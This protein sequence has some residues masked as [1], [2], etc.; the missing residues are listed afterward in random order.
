NKRLLCHRN[1]SE[2]EAARLLGRLFCCRMHRGERAVS[3]VKRKKNRKTSG[4][5]SRGGFPIESAKPVSDVAVAAVTVLPVAAGAAVCAATAGIA[6]ALI[7]AG[8]LGLLAHALRHALTWAAMAVALVSAWPAGGRSNWDSRLTVLA[9][10]VAAIV[11]TASPLPEV[12]VLAVVLLLA[13]L[14]RAHRDEANAGV[15]LLMAA[16]AA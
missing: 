2:M 9:A 13:A 11:M 10:F 3:K 14:A 15:V 6:A 8:S 1:G 5:A 16:T 4:P 12:N 7:A